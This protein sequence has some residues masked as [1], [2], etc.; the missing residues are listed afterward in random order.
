MKTET[1]ISELQRKVLNE[2][3]EHYSSDA[4]CMYIKFIASECGVDYRQA[5]LAV[6]A[7]ARKGLAQYVRGLFD[8][9]GMVAG[10]GYCCTFEGALLVKG[11]HNKETC[12]NI[13]DMVTGECQGCWEARR[14]YEFTEDHGKYKK[15]DKVKKEELGDDFKALYW[16]TE[17]EWFKDKK[18]IDCTP[19]PEWVCQECGNLDCVC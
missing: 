19:N 3:A 12:G 7:L 10:S 11:C 4:N 15:G 18:I 9:D 1:K 14:V 13:A 16:G 2:L 8:E 17:K 6:R 5:R